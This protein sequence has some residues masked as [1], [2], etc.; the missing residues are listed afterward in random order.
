MP[1]PYQLVRRMIVGRL[2]F[3]AYDQNTGRN[4]AVQLLKG[5]R[6]EQELIDRYAPVA[7]LCQAQTVRLLDVGVV[8]QPVSV[9]YLVRE[10]VPGESLCSRFARENTLPASV[11]LQLALEVLASLEEAHQSG[12]VHGRLSAEHVLWRRGEPEADEIKVLGYWPS[13]HPQTEFSPCAA[14]ELRLNEVPTPAADV[15]SVG[16]LLYRA[17]TGRYP[18]P[19][20]LPE[21][22]ALELPAEAEALRAC[23]SRAL[24]GSPQARYADAGALRQ[25]L[26]HLSVARSWAGGWGDESSTVALVLRPVRNELMATRRVTIW[27]LDD[28]PVVRHPEL[29]MA[30][31]NVRRQHQLHVMSPA[32]QSLLLEQLVQGQ[33][34]PPSVLLYGPRS[35]HKSIGLLR[36]LSQSAEV[37]RVLLSEPDQ[38]DVLHRALDLGGLEQHLA[39]PCSAAE[40]EEGIH[41]AVRRTRRCSS[42]YDA[43]RG[44]LM[45]SREGLLELS[46]ELTALPES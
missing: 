3:E 26:S 34:S 28:D 8:R 10:F 38:L 45:R 42:F 36:V 18:P 6:D 46:R 39:F 25:A 40:A 30:F 23:L 37:S 2:L 22:E 4:V 15:F 32:E 7:Q 14:P 17:V 20:G 5:V 29:A 1:K 21:G 44:R 31:E 35:L 41:R 13:N 16:A 11:A 43:I 33:L 9:G 12:L 27:V 19:E 24:R